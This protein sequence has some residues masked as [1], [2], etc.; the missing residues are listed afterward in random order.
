MLVLSGPSAERRHC[1]PDKGCGW[2]FGAPAINHAMNHHPL[3]QHDVPRVDTQIRPPINI[4]SPGGGAVGSPAVRRA[5]LPGRP[6]ARLTGGQSTCRPITRTT[7]RTRPAPQA[8]R[9]PH[10]QRGRR[11]QGPP[12][13]APLAITQPYAPQMTP[14]R[15]GTPLGCR[16]WVRRVAACRTIHLGGTPPRPVPPASQSP[17]SASPPITPAG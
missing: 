17:N 12:T 1:S 7:P 11:C 5:F 8:Q 3:R 16:G 4:R 15:G 9:H 6:P 14:A 2:L 13:V 10:P